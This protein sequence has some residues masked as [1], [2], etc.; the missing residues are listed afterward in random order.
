MRGVFLASVLLVTPA[1]G[2]AQDADVSAV[3]AAQRMVRAAGMPLRDGALEPGTLTVRVVRG[4]FSNNLPDQSVDVEVVGGR[5]MSA[6]TG[7]DGRAQFAHIDTEAQV[8]VSATV[9]GEL[10]ESETFAIPAE[11]GVRILLVAGGD[12]AH[13]A[14]QANAGASAMPP[15][16]TLAALPADDTRSTAGSTA[17]TVVKTVLACSTVFA[18]ALFVLQRRGKPPG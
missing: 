13:A 15:P 7:S 12:G 8:K 6:K 2:F 14:V 1:V 5:V 16:T 10:L 9:D 17:V 18:L 3:G 4:A 11:S